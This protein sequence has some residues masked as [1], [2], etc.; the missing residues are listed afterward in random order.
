M[1]AV[2]RSTQFF[3]KILYS[4]PVNHWCMARTSRQR[5]NLHPIPLY[6]SCYWGV[7]PPFLTVRCYSYY[8]NTLKKICKRRPFAKTYTSIFLRLGN[9]G[10]QWGPSQWV[11]RKKCQQIE[12]HDE[13]KNKALCYRNS[14]YDLRSQT[15]K[16]LW[17]ENQKYKNV[18]SIYQ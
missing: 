9:T 8:K 14:K 16:R 15:E 2:L 12:L 1:R 10:F 17:Q 13:Q 6:Q 4:C 11:D 7:P 3:C 18:H 5:N